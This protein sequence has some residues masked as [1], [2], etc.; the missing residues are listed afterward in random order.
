MPRPPR[1]LQHPESNVNSKLELQTLLLQ[2]LL[3][4]QQQLALQLGE[5]AV[6]LLGKSYSPNSRQ[7]CP[8]EVASSQTT[9]EDPVSDS[10]DLGMDA[11][12]AS[13]TQEADA[14][15]GGRSL[16]VPKLSSA[17]HS[18]GKMLR[19]SMT[20][21][22]LSEETKPWRRL[23]WFEKHVL[24]IIIALVVVINGV[25]M[26]IQLGFLG[27]EVDYALGI[28][29]TPT[30]MPGYFR[31]LDQVFLV[32]YMVEVS[33]RII[34]CGRHWFYSQ[35]EGLMLGNLLDLSIVLAGIM[36]L[37]IWELVFDDQSGDLLR[38]ARL[39][40]MLR[41][42]RVIK[43]MSVIRVAS[44]IRPLR[45][46]VRTIVVSSGALVW[47]LILLLVLQMFYAVLMCQS[48]YA[49]LLDDS[50][51]LDLRRNVNRQFGSFSKSFYTMFEITYSGG[52]WVN[53][54]R[55]IVTEFSPW[56]SIPFISYVIFV[57]FAI[58]KV[59]AALFI[60]E[61]LKQAS[62]D[63]HISMLE[64]LSISHSF[65]TKVRA[66]FDVTDNSRDGLVSRVELQKAMSHKIVQNYLHTLE[67]HAEDVTQ[68]FDLLDNGDGKV[69][70]SEFRDGLKRL[71]GQAR[72]LDVLAIRRDFARLREELGLWKQKIT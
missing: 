26:A 40:R 24:D 51:D 35:A 23:K 47:S 1:D 56:F 14:R 27:A 10:S 38:T 11:D 31:I 39:L 33:L 28:R 22:S 55:P 41:L 2:E 71:K 45:I 6:Q 70:F 19:A 17:S 7:E 52:T 21:L 61:T 32:V 9:K 72:A 5:M 12:W 42:L 13:N 43:V 63:Y 30:V 44:L 18:L 49:F 46:L 66:L 37:Y 20:P 50:I 34:I 16:D 64:S 58:M 60:R 53:V 36:E 54:A 3:Q 4:G 59:I 48:L 29:S 62:S 65:E 67:V 57:L 25:I 69:T 8:G 68:M 15:A